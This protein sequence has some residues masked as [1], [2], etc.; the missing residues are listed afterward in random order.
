LFCDWSDEV[1]AIVV[2]IG[3]ST[4]RG[5]Y[6]GEDMPKVTSYFTV[7]FM[8]I[9]SIIIIIVT[10]EHVYSDLKTARAL[11]KINIILHLIIIRALQ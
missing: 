2:D 3:S 4:F 8:M 10:K 5:G 1:G 7:V 11:Y 6:A 9:M